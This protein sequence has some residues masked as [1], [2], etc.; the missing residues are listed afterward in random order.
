MTTKSYFR[1][2][3][4]AMFSAFAVVWLF[5]ILQAAF[6]LK[7]FK[8]EFI[9]VPS[10]LA[11]V[12]G[13]AIAKIAILKRNLLEQHALL[14]ALTD[15]GQ[16]F[17]YLRNKKGEYQYVSPYCQELTG[18]S[19]EEFYQNSQQMEM[20]IHNEDLP[21]WHQHVEHMFRS[22][23]ESES[24]VIR[25]VS[26]SGTVRWI[27]HVCSSV[28]DYEGHF[29]GV[30][31]SNIDI[32]Q[33][34][35]L[36]QIKDQFLK[37]M[38]HEFRTPMNGILGCADL[39][40]SEVPDNSDLKKYI[41]IIQ[42]SSERLMQTL[43][44]I[45][46]L[47]RLGNAQSTIYSTNKPFDLLAMTQ[48]LIN[49]YQLRARIE[50]KKLQLSCTHRPETIEVLLPSEVMECILKN[51]LDNAVKFSCSGQI[52]VNLHLNHDSIDLSVKD[53]GIGIDPEFLPLIFE[54]FTQGSEGDTR[55]FDGTG[56]GLS[57]VKKLL[58]S[59]HGTIQVTSELKQGTTV[60]LQ[61]PFNPKN[62]QC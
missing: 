48:R 12:I 57:V 22:T 36:E 29:Q 16:E 44:N 38:S 45:L 26:K 11:I 8:L 42:S 43:D 41:E 54:E 50:G 33:R 28:F 5:F 14:R 31:S 59:M 32:T 7:D 53:Q 24:L 1:I 6:I 17:L 20:L 56:I 62:R 51:L 18:Y 49:L 25:I 58:T 2:Y 30:R 13:F 60:A 34:E 39:I 46:E 23:G 19:P 21:L 35:E 37:R 9:I 52:M 10:L 15:F 4:K 27:N 61:L 3:F 40:N 47:T 55:H